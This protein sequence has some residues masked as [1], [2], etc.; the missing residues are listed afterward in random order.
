M[1]SP[2]VT[3]RQFL[4]AAGLA[5]ASRAEAVETGKANPKLAPFDQLMTRFL[6]EEKPPGAA[7]AVSYHGRL[8]YSRGFGHAD[9]EKKE[10]VEPDS[11]F[12]IASVSKPFTATAVMHLV[13]KGKLKL[14]DKV[15]EILK[16]E[17]HL[18]RGHRVDPRL[19]QIEVLH[20][21]QHTGG[22]DRDKSFD[23]M[24]AATAEAVAKAFKVPL[25]IIP[26]QI[27]EYMMGQPL[28]FTPGTAYAYSNFGYCVLGRVI[29]AIAGH[30]YHEFVERQ[31]LAPLGIRRM[32]LGKNLLKDRAHRRGEILRQQEPQGPGHQW[33][34]DREASAAALWCRVRRDD[35]RQR[36]LDRFGRGPRALRVRLRQSEDLPGPE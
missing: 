9:R 4:A 13:Q 27:V 24:G 6:R 30:P 7:L 26:K 36:R 33:A 32:R 22:W 18:E 20:C 21:L 12:R 2:V 23:P 8:V 10:P 5:V 3:R 34:G 16:L 28:D 1:I 19:H 31:I 35:G 14:D 25:P 15:F 17:P 29:Q 11:L